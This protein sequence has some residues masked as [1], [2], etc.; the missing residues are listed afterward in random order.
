VVIEGVVFD[1]DDTLYF[2]RE[3]VRSGFRHVATV[4]AT[5]EAELTT[6]FEWLWNE[7]ETGRRGDTFDQFLS[8]FPAVHD[9]FSTSELVDEY[10]SHRP[11]IS[12]IP[13]IA[14]SLASMQRRGLRLG[15]LSDG[16]LASQE[17]K[18]AALDLASWLDPIILTAGLG[19]S[20]AKPATGGFEMIRSLWGIDGDRLAYVADNPLKDF[21]GPRE[22]GWHTIRLR[23]A[24]Q[25]RYALDSRAGP[26][27]PDVEVGAISE[28][29]A[30][31][32]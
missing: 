11:S 12:L 29:V 15:A 13:G 26:V 19:P 17:A 10:R 30:L 2:E 32:R 27:R 22:L 14:E 21:A 25:L 8:V 18:A 7:F 5:S 6:F 31:V 1:I 3:Y 24:P 9:R 20:Y 16:A 23:L 28:L 4:V